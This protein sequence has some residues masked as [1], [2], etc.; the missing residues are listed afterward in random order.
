[1]G[2]SRGARQAGEIPDMTAPL[3]FTGRIPIPDLA[4]RGRER[5]NPEKSAS[6]SSEKFCGCVH[7]VEFRRVYVQ[8]D[9][10]GMLN[11]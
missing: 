4:K 9:E 1:M 10:R 7:L 6:D 11:N 2:K 3:R 8:T 5:S